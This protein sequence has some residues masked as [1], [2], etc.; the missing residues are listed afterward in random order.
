MTAELQHETSALSLD[1]LDR[2]P[3]IGKLVRRRRAHAEAMH[4]LLSELAILLEVVAEG[5]TSDQMK[6]LSPQ[7]VLSLSPSD[8]F[9]DD[10]PIVAGFADPPQL[11]V[12]VQGEREHPGHDVAGIGVLDEDADLVAAL[13]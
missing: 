11:R 12:P 2:R 10:D 7:C 9:K 3:E 13:L 8:A 1:K 6:P 4:P 5:A